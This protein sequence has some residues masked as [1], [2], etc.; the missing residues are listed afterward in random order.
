M[1]VPQRSPRGVIRFGAFEVD[2]R[3]GELRRHGTKVPLQQ[4][5]FR[6]LALLLERPGEVVTRE[7]LRH[8]IWADSFVAFDE[9]LDAAIYKLRTALGDSA[10]HPQ[11]VETLP[12]RGYRFIGAVEGGVTAWEGERSE[13]P[14]A[15]QNSQPWFKRWPVA[16]AAGLV[17]LVVVLMLAANAGGL[18]DRLEKRSRSG[19]IHSIAVLPLVNLSGD[20]AQEYFA[21]GMTE[22]LVTR[23]GKVGGLRVISYT[24]AMHSK[25]THETLPEIGR[26]LNA[27]VIVEGAVL[28]A[29]NRVRVTAQLVDAATDRHVWAE[30]YERD[31][32]DVLGLQNELAQAIAR[33]IQVRLSPSEQTTA[34]SASAGPVSPQ[35][36]DLYL[37]GRYEWNDW[38]EPGLKKSIQYF[39]EVIQTDPGYAPAW[40]G[41]SD[42]YSLLGIFGFLPP[43][44]T[45]PKAKAAALKA[46]ELD[47][48]LSEAHVS[49]SGVRLHMEWSWSGSERELRRAIALDPNNAMAH[50]WYGYLFSATGRF[51]EAIAETKR[52]LELD[53]LSPN[54]QN[55]LGAAFYRAGRYDEALR[56][57]REVPGPDVNSETRHRRIGAIYER[58]GK[59]R[60]AM[61]EWLT[62]LRL[63]GKEELAASV[64]RKYVSSGFAEAKKTFLRGDLREMQMR[65]EGAYPRPLAIDVAADYALLEEKSNAVEWLNRALR[66]RDASLMYLKVDDR[67]EAVR[68]DPRFRDIVRRIGLP[69]DPAVAGVF[70]RGN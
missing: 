9:G 65:V 17:M 68:S 52:A 59:Q 37:K 70:D 60:E 1:E 51:D 54:K 8:A 62:A 26:Q 50:Q 6:V 3:A 66:E 33:E 63:A 57:L 47:E 10:E 25:D 35:A 15:E 53:P 69:L 39:E 42:A 48:A 13:P 61:A 43:N 29:G 36:Y 45:L 67:F 38:T 5:P 16:F 21:E 12:R 32:R 40:A 14:P 58:T 56:Y 20:S 41:L 55:S 49:L 22:A 23:L 34:Q 7:E 4:Q 28:R 18:R 27:D 11:F 46:I 24:S 31:V 44:V 30:S 64:E 2:L 19:Q